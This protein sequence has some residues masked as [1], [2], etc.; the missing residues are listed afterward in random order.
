MNAK[1]QRDIF[2]SNLRRLVHE[3]G[4]D[5]RTIAVKLGVSDMTV[6]NWINGTKYPRINRI[7]ALAE[8]FN[9]KMSELMEEQPPTNIIPTSRRTVRIPVLGEIACGEP[10]YVE[11]NFSWYKEE[12]ADFVPNGNVFYL[13][14][15]GD[16]M[17]PTIPNGAY[18]LVREQPTVETGEI[19]AVLV[20]GNTEATLKRVKRQGEIVILDPDNPAYN[21][22][23]I[24]ESN[25]AKIIGKAL[26]YTR[27]L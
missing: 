18:V 16:S 26:K 10:L 4:I 21:P 2:A 7:Q 23:I 17:E 27:D 24:T 20:N 13:V 19:A 12:I 1:S 5:Q 6:S 3:R 15:K 22:I 14:A 11:E 9:V 8:L 25:P